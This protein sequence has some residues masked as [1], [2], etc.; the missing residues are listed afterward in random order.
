M[1]LF[2]RSQRSSGVTPPVEHNDSI[3]PA[4][5]IK[6][7][8]ILTIGI[9]TPLPNESALFLNQGLSAAL[10]LS[11][12]YTYSVIPLAG[13]NTRVNLFEQAK[14]ALESCNILITFGV[15]CANVTTEACALSTPIPIINLGLRASQQARI[16]PNTAFTILTEYNYQTQVAL[17]TKL[18]PHAKNICILYR[19]HSELSGEEAMELKAAFQ[20]A[21]ITVSTHVL[22]HATHIDNQLSAL[23]KSYDSLFIMPHTVTAHNLQELI[24]YCTTKNITLCSQE[25]DLVTL[26]AHVGFTEYEKELGLF[27]GYLIRD[28]FE[29]KKNLTPGT[30]ITHTPVYRCT[31]NKTKFDY[32]NSILSPED[33]TLLEHIHMIHQPTLPSIKPTSP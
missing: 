13:D 31:I 20:N 10:K 33:S 27:A 3:K 7:K 25:K 16:M 4:Q 9:L 18:K 29:G 2:W 26:G 32:H 1:A 15:T 28:F 22:V 11:T 17:F 30:V 6:T 12:H 24:T 21:G 14:Q 5:A 8:P 19:R 23:H